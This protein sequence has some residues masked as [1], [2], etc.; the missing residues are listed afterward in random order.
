MARLVRAAPALEMVD[1]PAHKE[2]FCMQAF[3]VYNDNDKDNA[4]L[5]LKELIH[6]FLV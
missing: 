3:T 6:F 2:I 1:P 5:I 4:N